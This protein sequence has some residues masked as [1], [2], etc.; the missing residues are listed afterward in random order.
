MSEVS[1]GEYGREC[2]IGWHIGTVNVGGTEHKAGV[3]ESSG[4]CSDCGRSSIIAFSD[5][6]H[7]TV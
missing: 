6:V 3:V 1:D 2:L 4:R 5:R 7:S